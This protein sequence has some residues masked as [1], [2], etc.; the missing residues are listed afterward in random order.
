V[1][2][3]AANGKGLAAVWVFEKLQF[4]AVPLLNKG[5]QFSTFSEARIAANYC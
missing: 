5:S 4:N 2:A 3:V 1:I